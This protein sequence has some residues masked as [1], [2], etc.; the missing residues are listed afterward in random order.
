MTCIG[1]VMVA[2]SSSAVSDN[3]Y[4]AVMHHTVLHTIRVIIGI[5]LAAA[6]FL[7]KPNRLKQLSPVILIIGVTMLLLVF[8]P[9]IGITVNGA[10]R[11]VYMGYF[12]FQP[13][14]FFK[15][16]FILFSAYF[17]EKY[18]NDGNNIYLLSIFF[19]YCLASASLLMQPDFGSFALMSAM[20]LLMI[21]LVSGLTPRLALIILVALVVATYLIIS[22]PYRLE[23]VQ[24][25]LDPWRDRYGSGFQLIQA[26]IAE[27]NGGLFGV[28]LGASIQKMLYLPEAH[29]D[30]TISI[31]AEEA[32]MLGVFFVIFAGIYLYILLMNFS[33]VLMKRDFR[34]ESYTVFIIANMIFVQLLINIG[35]NYGVL[36]TK[37]VP[38]PF[39]GYGGT[40]VVV[41]LMLIG[42]VLS[43]FRTLSDAHQGDN[44][45]NA[46]MSRLRS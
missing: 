4:D 31:L 17:I 45:F 42:V 40:S 21:F 38:L 44:T 8:V 36:P 3:H 37:G 9:S 12:V 16:G 41:H 22:E 46:A 13:Y 19:V 2:S 10:T 33:L 15:F 43:F 27:G 35:V 30:F 5:V 24:I 32:G 20:A 18:K 14:E 6:I 7:I 34:Y 26:L 39:M 1:I 11:W 25:L 23:R 28:G 29:T